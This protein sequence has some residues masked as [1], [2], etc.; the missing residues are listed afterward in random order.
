MEDYF[1][2]T[3][4]QNYRYIIDE[5]FEKNKEEGFG[6]F[7]NDY[8]DDTLWWGL[9]WVNAW[10]LTGNSKYLDMAKIDC[11][12]AYTFRDDTCGGGVWWSTEKGYKNAIT[13]ELFIKLAATLHNRLP[14]NTKY[15]EQAV[16]VWNWFNNSGMINANN[17]INDG[18]NNECK[19]NNGAEFSYNQG[20]ILGGLVELHKATNDE[21][22]LTEAKKIVEAVFRSEKL[23]PNGIL[24]D[25]G[26]GNCADVASFKGIFVRN[27]G[28]L[29]RYLPDKPYST[30][31][32]NQ[33]N[34]IWENNRNALN[35]FGMNWEGPLDE[36]DGA[37]QHSAFEAFVAAF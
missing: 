6:D 7:T 35:H 27:L 4:S 23:T 29:N 17:L 30:W 12:Y 26:C 9:A 3:G 20:V 16:E 15:L 25:P 36:T 5:I 28:E 37:R 21:V 32:R 31:L 8:I 14:G 2:V 18:L 19:N 10:E 11:D 1:K 13:N 33:A 34:S 22:Y 24:K